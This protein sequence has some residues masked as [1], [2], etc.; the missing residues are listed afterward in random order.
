MEPIRITDISETVTEVKPQHGG[1]YLVTSKRIG[2]DQYGHQW[3]SFHTRLILDGEPPK[4]G[5]VVKGNRADH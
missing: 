5:D 2:V 1:G 4:V 3:H